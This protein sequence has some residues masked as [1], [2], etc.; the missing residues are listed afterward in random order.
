MRDELT[1]WG[2]GQLFAFSGV[3][4]STSFDYGLT[5]RS[6]EQ[7]FR[8]VL[9]GEAQ[10]QVGTIRSAR[11]GVD[12]W[13]LETE[14]GS[15]RGVFVDAFHVLLEGRL[16][17][18]E[19]GR[20][21]AV[22]ILQ[23]GNRCLIASLGFLNPE[24]LR[25]DLDQLIAKR[26]SWAEAVLD[27]WQPPQSWQ[28][29]GIKALQQMKGM[30]YSAEGQF[31]HRATTPDRWPHR[32]VWLW[33]SAFHAIGYRHFDPELARDALN[34]V[35]DA[36]LPDGQIA[37]CASPYVTGLQHSQ[38]PVLAW[39]LQLLLDTEQ[40][41]EWLRSC[42]P[43]LTAYL[44]WFERRRV[45]QVGEEMCFGWVEDGHTSE[46]H[47]SVCDE[48]GMDNSARFTGT[49]VLRALD[50]C[51]L[52]AREY[53]V[54]AELAQ[55]LGED[56]APW[57]EKA[58]TLSRIIH[59]DFWD[60]TK[61]LYCDVDHA[62]G[63][64]T[65]VESVCGF[66]PLILGALPEGR[67]ERLLQALRDPQRFGTPCPLPSLPPCEA[68]YDQDMWNG[69]V[70]LNCS[71]LVIQGLLRN[72]QGELAAE[73]RERT[74]TIMQQWQQELG[75]IFEFYDDQNEQAPTSLPRKGSCDPESSPYHQVMQDFGW[76]A[77]LAVDLMSTVIGR[78]HAD[79]S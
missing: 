21:K 69:P 2:S 71:W 72:G 51:C 75:C 79:A 42:F 37:I 77:T 39:A 34:A 67:L 28:A 25:S 15:L 8:V 48:S 12:W 52:M 24:H 70:W 23:E 56:S 41:R 33:D 6:V 64:S 38:P 29:L 14:Q 61:G 9:P 17:I 78:A 4:G 5:L 73:I 63:S 11:F 50:L 7:G 60:E 45:L 74:L 65:A 30:V 47:W 62:S 40:D 13:E 53:Q 26:R 68:G 35:F 20:N 46:G 49:G 32:L 59:R 57:Q 55:A 43:K 27:R 58:E 18:E 76:S 10:L 1:V 19:A 36:Q 22:Q 54:M 16:E 3:D 44:A 66:Y 31:Q